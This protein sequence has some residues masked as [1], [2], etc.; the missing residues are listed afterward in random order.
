MS[1]QTSLKTYLQSHIPIS[2]AMG[3]CVE[4]AS[5]EKVI[6][7]APFANNINHKKTVFG[8]S[9]HAVATLACWSLL[10]LNLEEVQI[11]I[12]R[13]EVDYRAP[14]DGDFKAEC[15]LP[16]RDVW[17]KFIKTLQLKGKARLA[18]TATISHQGRLAVNYQGT[19]AAF[20]Q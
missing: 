18:L 14:V 16:E 1:D 11:V 15:V 7:T 13:S 12:T 2:E 20:N 4:H 19:F 3:V 17:Q 9:L 6:L 8:G 10:H 5:K